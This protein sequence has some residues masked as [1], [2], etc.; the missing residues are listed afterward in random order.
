MYSCGRL[1]RG[2]DEKK[3]FFLFDENLL[4]LLLFYCVYDIED[5]EEEY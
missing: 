1:W 4:A 5:E 3:I 2:H